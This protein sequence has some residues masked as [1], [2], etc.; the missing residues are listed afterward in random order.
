MW[1]VYYLVI[2]IGYDYW[3]WN[4]SPDW[5]NPACAL[6]PLA[7][8]RGNFH[9]EFIAIQ[10]QLSPLHVW[11]WPVS[12][13]LMET[14]AVHWLECVAWKSTRWEGW[15]GVGGSVHPGLQ[16]PPPTYWPLQHRT[17]LH[18]TKQIHRWSSKTRRASCSW[19]TPRK[20]SLLCYDNGDRI[21]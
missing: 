21:K 9:S 13:W 7:C 12:C 11:V 1:R 17:V 6:P 16:H 19:G 15:W 18:D 4:H 8:V 3:Y 2:P 20:I 14:G 10:L 5:S